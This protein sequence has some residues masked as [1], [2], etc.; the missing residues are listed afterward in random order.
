MK[1]EGKSRMPAKAEANQPTVADKN[2]KAKKGATPLMRKQRLR[3]HP[4]P[5]IAASKSEPK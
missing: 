2:N 5:R 1:R 4:T 3:F